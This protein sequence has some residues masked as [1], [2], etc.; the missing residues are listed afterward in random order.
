VG[1]TPP[2]R[3]K[4]LIF[5]FRVFVAVHLHASGAG[6]GLG[7]ELFAFFPFYFRAAKTR[8]PVGLKMRSSSPYHQQ[9]TRAIVK[10][11]ETSNP[12][13]VRSMAMEGRRQRTILGNRRG[14]ILAF[15]VSPSFHPF[16]FGIHEICSFY[17]VLNHSR[18]LDYTNIALLFHHLSNF[19][20]SRSL[21]NHSSLQSP[22][23]RW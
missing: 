8:L 21:F 11:R 12:P 10:Q 17:V 22:A 16:P 15:V 23:S 14:S 5:S 9:E 18:S 6:M 3:S 19:K 4:T 7:G 20:P 2:S 1:S 13:A